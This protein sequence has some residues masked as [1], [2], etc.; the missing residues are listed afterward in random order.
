M[1]SSSHPGSFTS[2]KENCWQI[3]TICSV[4]DWKK[5]P[6]P[7][8]PPALLGRESRRS[9]VYTNISEAKP[10]FQVFLPKFESFVN[11]ISSS[12]RLKMAMKSFPPFKGVPATQ[13]QRLQP[14][15]GFYRD[16]TSAAFPPARR[17][18]CCNKRSGGEAPSPP[19]CALFM[20]SIY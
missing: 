5:K 4:G 15:Q 3:G 18:N 14:H 20:F 16:L 7:Q 11:N 2:P 9:F 10:A 13:K 12:I 1:A 6:Q 19:K 8:H 17:N